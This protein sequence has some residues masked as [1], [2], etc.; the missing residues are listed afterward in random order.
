MRTNWSRD[1]WSLGSYSFVAKG[2]GRDEVRAL[3]RPVGDRVFFAGEATYSKFNSTVHAAYE[4]GQKAAAAVIAT[5]ANR[6]AIIGAGISGLAAAQILAKAGLT[7]TIFEARDRIGGRV[8]TVD[9]LGTPLD[10]G[11]AWIH[12]VTGNP[13]TRLSDALGIRRVPTGEGFA[14]R[15]GSGRKLGANAALGWLFKEAETQVMFGADLG[16]I[17]AGMLEMGDGYAGED[18]TFPG[19]FAQI[20]AG[21]EGNYGVELSSPVLSVT[22]ADQGVRLGLKDGETQGFDAVIVSVPLGVLKA[23]AI[24]FDP[25][26]PADKR[27]A[28]EWMGM[29]TLDKVAL[30]FETAF[31]DEAEWIYTPRD[32]RP[33]GQF[34]QWFNLH[35]STGEPIIVAL[36]GGSAALALADRSDD[37]MVEMA[38]DTLMR[39]YPV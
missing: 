29:G 36:N 24:A 30:R 18:V 35:P 38:L 37:A 10:A 2:T 5:E 7:V 16:Q 9:D 21:L 23:E 14:V 15:D 39:A 33:R 26:L 19:G 6:I 28:I 3:E 11:A 25:P 20:F 22:L 32:D 1:P 31:W 4:S 8:W 27:R 34:N 17:D 12:G 13:L